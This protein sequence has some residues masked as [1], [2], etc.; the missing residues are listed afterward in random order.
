[1][2][3]ASHQH[4]IHDN[5]LRTTQLRGIEVS[6]FDMSLINRLQ[7]VTACCQ[8]ATKHRVVKR[9]CHMRM[10]LSISALHFCVMSFA[11]S[12]SPQV[13]DAGVA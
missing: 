11:L 8:S 9:A 7:S 6:E 10:H 13:Q 3:P 2:C 12:S 5:I 1:M 4:K